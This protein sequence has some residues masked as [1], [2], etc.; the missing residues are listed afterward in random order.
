MTHILTGLMLGLYVLQ[1]LGDPLVIEE[2]ERLSESLTSALFDGVA[3]AAHP[4][5]QT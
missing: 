5:S 4:H 2:W 3:P 1:V